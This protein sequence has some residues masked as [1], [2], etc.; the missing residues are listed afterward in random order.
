M[1]GITATTTELNYVDG[2]TSSIQTQL[3]DKVAK[4]NSAQAKAYGTTSGG[5]ETT[6]KVASSASASTLAYRGTNGVLAVGT[7]T[8]NE[9]A[10]TKAYVDAVIPSQSG[11]SGKYLTTNGTS[12]S[13]A[14]VDAL[15]SQSGNAGKYLTTN[16]TTASW[17][18]IEE[19]T[20]NE[21]ETLWNSI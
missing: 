19:Y 5:V 14:V 9:H 21:V 20:A 7:P 1:D 16:G 4:N 10:A 12:V 17:I 13:W 8:S 2:V 15:P 6:W 18:A 11:N 3:D